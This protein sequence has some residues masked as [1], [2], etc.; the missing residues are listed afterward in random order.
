MAKRRASSAASTDTISPND[1][2]RSTQSESPGTKKR[3][4]DQTTSQSTNETS[5]PHGLRPRPKPKAPA[6]KTTFAYATLRL[7][8]EAAEE[9]AEEAEAG[10]ERLKKDVKLLAKENQHFKDLTLAGDHQGR[11]FV[12]DDYTI[13]PNVK[14]FFGMIADWASE[15]AHEGHL[16][17]HLK[18]RGTVNV[19]SVLR[20]E[21]KQSLTEVM[22]KTAEETFPWTPAA[23][24]LAVETIVAY[25]TSTIFIGRPF[26]FLSKTGLDML[27]DAEVSI[28]N[29]RKHMKGRPFI[30]ACRINMLTCSQMARM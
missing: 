2:D 3:K 26:H 18:L 24:R 16:V 1:S 11:D 7:K 25:K 15:W 5:T 8:K 20:G 17:Q 12:Q 28:D 6:T 13:C 29:I 4:G 21:R 19:V 9:R 14:V 10:I 23:C 27:K 22:R 30:S